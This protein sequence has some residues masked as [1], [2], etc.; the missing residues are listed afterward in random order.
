MVNVC[1]C[2]IT[3]ENSTRHRKGINNLSSENFESE[4][5]LEEK[6]REKMLEDMIAMT[7]EW[8]EQ[9]RVAGKVIKSDVEVIFSIYL[10]EFN[11]FFLL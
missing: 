7:K 5:A 9:S 11:S 3:E 6:R 8:K 2:F 10:I 4:L 1:I